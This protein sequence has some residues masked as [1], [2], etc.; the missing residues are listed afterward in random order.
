VNDKELGEASWAIAEDCLDLLPRDD[1]PM[2]GTVLIH[3]VAVWLN[4]IPEGARPPA[5]MQWL[6]MLH[7]QLDRNHV[8][9]I[10][11][12]GDED[13]GESFSTISVH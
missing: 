2:T 4:A 8:I 1:L 7:R 12:V 3:L 11:S 10:V 5:Y 6:D 13:E 9:K